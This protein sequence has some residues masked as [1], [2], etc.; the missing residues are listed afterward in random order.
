MN[1]ATTDSVVMVTVDPAE[2]NVGG[3]QQGM[4]RNMLQDLCFLMLT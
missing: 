1:L 4:L 3:N 2:D